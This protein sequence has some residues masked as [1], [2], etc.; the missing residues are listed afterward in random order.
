MVLWWKCIEN[1]TH[2]ILGHRYLGPRRVRAACAQEHRGCWRETPRRSWCKCF[3][4]RQVS[5]SC[6]VGRFCT[7]FRRIQTH[8]PLYIHVRHIHRYTFRIQMQPFRALFPICTTQ[9]LQKNTLE[10]DV[11][12]FLSYIL[13]MSASGWNRCMT[14]NLVVGDA[15]VYHVDKHIPCCLGC[16]ARAPPRLPLSVHLRCCFWRHWSLALAFLPSLALSLRSRSLPPS[17]SP[18][19]HV[20]ISCL[21]LTH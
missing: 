19:M 6:V 8:M 12:I 5:C 21:A 13:E 16:A 18:C 3:L 20:S 4:G 14:T 7:R 1:G 2:R 11:G 10:Y 17:L 9:T 15:A